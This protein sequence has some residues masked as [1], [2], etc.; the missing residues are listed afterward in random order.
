MRWLTL[1]PNL[2]LISVADFLDFSSGSF[3]SRLKAKSGLPADNDLELPIGSGTIALTNPT[4]EA[5]GN[6]TNGI[7]EITGSGT[8]ASIAPSASGRAVLTGDPAAGRGAIGLESLGV[9]RFPGGGTKSF[10]FNFKPLTRGY[11]ANS[12]FG[13]ELANG[14]GQFV[15][16]L[17]GAHKRYFV[18][19]TGFAGVEAAFDAGYESSATLAAGA[20]GTIT[21]D[22]VTPPQSG[23]KFIY[24]SGFVVVTLYEYAPAGI[25]YPA[26][27]LIEVQDNAGNWLTILNKSDFDTNAYSAKFQPFF[28]SVYQIF[29]A[30]FRLTTTARPGKQVWITKLE[31]FADRPEGFETPQYPTSAGDQ[32]DVHSEYLFTTANRTAQTLIGP[33]TLQFNGGATQTASLRGSK[34]IGT[35]STADTITVVGAAV[36]DIVSVSRGRDSFVSAAN[37]VQFDSTGLGGVVVSVIVERFV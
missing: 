23:Y 20:T 34:T 4:T 28:A 26:S 15:D 7:P 16:R 3:R 13:G 10:D 30:K 17:L 33:G 12:F 14:V 27:M 6:L 24:G 31:Y 36:G 1:F 21:V 37:T 8:A 32:Q 29:Q 18:S 2:K 19:S 25:E 9:N 11:I 22:F 5:I 35:P